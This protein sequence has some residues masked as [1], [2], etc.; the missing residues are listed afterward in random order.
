MSGNVIPFGRPTPADAEEH[1]AGQMRCFGCSH[2]WEGIA[3]VG[4]PGP[5]E[6]PACGAQKGVWRG[7]WWPCNGEHVRKCECDNF[8]F[9]ITPEGHQCANCGTFQ[10]Y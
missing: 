4:T 1:G 10:K 7:A 9:F 5:F 6:C 2:E 3:P 8:L